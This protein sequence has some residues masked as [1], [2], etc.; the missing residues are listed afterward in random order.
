MPFVFDDQSLVDQYEHDPAS[1]Q[2]LQIRSYWRN[3]RALTHFSCLLSMRLHGM[4]AWRW[5]IENLVIHTANAF[6][7]SALFGFWAAVLF[8]VHPIAGGL[9]LYISTRADLFMTFASLLFA[10][11]A[12]K[13]GAWWILSVLMLW[14][15]RSAK[16]CG[17]AACG[18]LYVTA[19]FFAGRT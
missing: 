12:M 14:L 11:A 3:T 4:H 17:P 18:I 16:A 6:L 8:F 2:R 10:A 19:L 5:H 7:V 1:W 15:S 13:G 9:C